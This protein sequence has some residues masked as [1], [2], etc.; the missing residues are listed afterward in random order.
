MHQRF[1][2]LIRGSIWSFIF[3]IIY[4]ICPLET[5]AAF[6]LLSDGSDGPFSP[7]QNTTL[8]VPADGVF[9]FTSIHIP[10][11]VHIT[12]EGNAASSVEANAVPTS[13][14]YPIV[15]VR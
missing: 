5:E 1:S 13:A 7:T 8:Q 4:W 12:F 6:R 3:L 2:R 14:W 11:G 10:D 9:N 15:I